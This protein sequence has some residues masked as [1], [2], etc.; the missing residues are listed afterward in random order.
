MENHFINYIEG[1]IV[2]AEDCSK[3]LSFVPQSHIA[4]CSMYGDTLTKFN[5]DLNS[6]LFNEI[7]DE[8]YK[9]YNSTLMEYDARRLVVEKII[10]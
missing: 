7:K 8:Q 4:L 5:F 3:Y 10:L 1:T 9:F 6:P 2:T